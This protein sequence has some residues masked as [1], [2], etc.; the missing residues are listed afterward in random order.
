[1]NKKQI[2]IK[3]NNVFNKLLI[4]VKFILL[5]LFSL[6]FLYLI[7]KSKL[8]NVINYNKE[9]FLINEILNVKKVICKVMIT[10]YGVR[11]G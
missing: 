5:P 3:L 6:K 4:I 11:T 10:S 1:M 8:T 9:S 7:L 2:I